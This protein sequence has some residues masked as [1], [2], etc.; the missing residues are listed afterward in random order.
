MLRS[1]AT[2]DDVNLILHL[3]EM[4]REDKMRE[5]RNWFV[6]NFRPQTLEE[7]QKLVPVGSDENAFFRQ[8]TSYW[9]MV[10]SFIVG[11]VLSEDLFF[12]S[13]RELLLCWVRVRPFLG[14]LREFNKD[15]FTLHNLEKVSLKYIEWLNARA[16]GSF[17]AFAKRVG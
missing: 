3:Y 9:D 2:Y 16:E 8:V 7:M 15:P 17:E 5:A 1:R 13:N 10:A 6:K 12:E 11:G 14:A 4:R